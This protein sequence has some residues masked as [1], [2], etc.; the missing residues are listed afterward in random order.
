MIW[1]NGNSFFPYVSE[2]RS[3]KWCIESMPDKR[4]AAHRSRLP[5]PLWQVSQQHKVETF[6]YNHT[7]VQGS[8]IWT[9]DS[10]LDFGLY[11]ML[12]RLFGHPCQWHDK[13]RPKDLKSYYRKFPSFKGSITK[14]RI[15]LTNV[16]KRD[17]RPLCVIRHHLLGFYSAL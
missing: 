9:L 3:L 7:R 17:I 15:V 8:I 6:F 4:H 12:V 13:W 10:R 11:K 1:W 14:K 2:P 5:L 16:H